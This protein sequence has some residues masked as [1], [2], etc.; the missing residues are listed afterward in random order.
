M[1]AGT[2]WLTSL[3]KLARIDSQVSPAASSVGPGSPLALLLL[4]AAA[5]PAQANAASAATAALKA[6]AL[7]SLAGLIASPVSETEF[8]SPYANEA[9][10]PKAWGCDPRCR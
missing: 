4:L 6:R 8:V 5:H 9:C 1:R 2:P 7:L 10:N 3:F